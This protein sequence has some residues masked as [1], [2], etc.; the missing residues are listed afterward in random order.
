V[1]KFNTKMAIN[2]FALA[3]DKVTQKN[4][5]DVWKALLP[6]SVHEFTSFDKAIQG[7]GIQE[8]IVKLG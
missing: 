4:M 7:T 2:N 6:K 8:K 3:W 5:N 1:E